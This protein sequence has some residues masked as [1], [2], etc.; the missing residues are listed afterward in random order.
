[1][2]KLTWFTLVSLLLSG[3]HT[4]DSVKDVISSQSAGSS[5]SELVERV[6]VLMV[7]ND[8]DCLVSSGCGPRFS[9]LSEDLRN[10]TVTLTGKVNK[11]L[12]GHLITVQGKLAKAVEGVKAEVLNVQ[13]TIAITNVPTQSFLE[14]QSDKYM[15]E[16]YGCN[17]F[18]DKTYHWH[19]EGK[20]P[21]LS[22]LL[23]NNSESG[24]SIELIYDGVSTELQREIKLPKDLE[25]CGA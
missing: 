23:K 9:L 1:M 13:N 6:G 2:K 15:S 24:Q 16:V 25:P 7:L 8:E 10:R 21:Y 4:V 17:L 22:A 12:A 19:I 3:C 14:T 18:W 11:S 5:S 20:Q